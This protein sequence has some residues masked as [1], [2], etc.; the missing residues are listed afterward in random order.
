MQAALPVVAVPQQAAAF[1]FERLIVD[2]GV[3]PGGLLA[4][5]PQG[6]LLVPI[7]LAAAIWAF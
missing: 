7:M 4:P 1:L 3:G 6:A 2:R 5:L